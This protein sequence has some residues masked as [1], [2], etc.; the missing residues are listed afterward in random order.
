MQ[1]HDTLLRVC[2]NIVIPNLQFRESDKEV[3]DENFIEYV[4]RDVEGSDTDTRR[5]MA[6]ELVKAL[7]ASFKET[8]TAAMSGYVGKLLAEYA[9]SPAQCWKQKD[10]AIFLITALTVRSKTDT[11]GATSTNEL[12]NIGDF[13][14]NHIVPELQQPAGR[15]SDLLKADALKFLTTFRQQIPKQTVLQLMPSVAGLLVSEHNVVHSYAAIC[16]E[17]MLTVK[18]GPGAR[19]RP[20]LR[21]SAPDLV[22][23]RDQLLHN[24]FL[25]LTLPESG[26]NDYLMKT[27]MRVVAVLGPEAK[28]VAPTC[29]AKLA[30]ILTELAKNP[31]NPSFSHYLFE[32][33]AALIR[34]CGSDPGA[35]AWKT[36]SSSLHPQGCV[37]SPR[38]SSS[39]T[40]CALS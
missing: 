33:V 17:R 9:A 6:S 10:C 29:M 30:G 22:P 15:G 36:H 25:A 11:Q 20:D 2:E 19:G 27:I 38:R 18:D 16:V 13:F 7:T 32:A 21:F 37:A 26:E 39:T 35:S 28:P 4:R 34:H 40:A 3:F 23:F 31:R 1:D 8:V 12:V 24:L 5:R 14:A